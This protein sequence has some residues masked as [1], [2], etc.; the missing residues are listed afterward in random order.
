MGEWET[1]R[2]GDCS[3]SPN[4]SISQSL[5][6]PVTQFHTTSSI[7]PITAVRLSKALGMKEE[8]VAYS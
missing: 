7:N 2:M 6:L 8:R 1:E 5:N 3:Q 4:L